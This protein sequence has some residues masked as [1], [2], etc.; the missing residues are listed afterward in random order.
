LWAIL[1]CSVSSLV[2]QREVSSVTSTPSF[3]ARPTFTA[4]STPTRTPRPSPTPTRTYTPT[5]TPIPT[6]TPI[7]TKTPLP[8]NT[9]L[10]SLTPTITDTPLPPTATTR[11][12]PRPTRVPTKTPIPKPTNTPPPP[13]TAA[14]GG[15]FVQCGGY[16]GVTGYIK[17]A[18][19]DPYPNVV[20]GVWSDDWQGRVSGPSEADGKYDVDLGDVPAGNFMVAVVKVETCST[21]D[22]LPTARD[23]QRLSNVKGVTITE[24]CT[25]EGVV[26]VSV[27]NFTGP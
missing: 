19:G 23:C 24:E 14:I 11:P 16:R 1:A 6:D 4:T 8:T 9:P 25:G 22:G 27:V 21:R 18:S 26:Q 2:P 7:P 12:T 17:H 10:P 3:T 15:G 5:A 20:V 13:F